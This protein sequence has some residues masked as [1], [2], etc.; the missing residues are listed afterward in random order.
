MTCTSTIK[1]T[2]DALFVFRPF[3][4]SLLYRR[5]TQLRPQGLFH[6]QWYMPLLPICVVS[7]GLAKRHAP[8]ALST[9]S[10]QN[11]SRRLL[12]CA[13]TWQSIALHTNTRSQLC[14]YLC[15]GSSPLLLTRLDFCIY[16]RTVRTEIM[17]R[18]VNFGKPFHIR[19]FHTFRND[20]RKTFV[21]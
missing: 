16:F 1:L 21:P 8:G 2:D 5:N 10:L 19:C 6:Q 4:W 7:F 20:H 18:L 12:Y 15:D 11:Q 17:L 3:P 13:Q 14:I 9:I